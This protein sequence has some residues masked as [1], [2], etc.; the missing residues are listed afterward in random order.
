MWGFRKPPFPEASS[1]L[2]SAVSLNP[3]NLE[4][5]NVLE[6]GVNRHTQE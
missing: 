6:T 1:N 3:L 4:Q 2:K 5:T